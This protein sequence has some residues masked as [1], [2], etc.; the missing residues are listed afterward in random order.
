MSKFFW[1]F[2]FSA[3]WAN[4][5]AQT[6]SDS[7]YTYKRINRSLSFAQLTFGGDCL[8]LAD[9][10]RI[11]NSQTLGDFGT[12][13]MPR[14]T[15]GGLHFW[16][17]ADFYVTFPLGISFR[18]TPAFAESY[19]HQ[20]GVE[21]GLKI[22]PFALKPGRISPYVG[23]SFQPFSFGYLDKAIELPKPGTRYERFITPWQTGLTYTGK[24]YLFTAGMRYNRQNQFDYH[25]APNATER[26]HVS[27][28][29]VHL[30]ILRYLDSDKSVGTPH[31]VGQENAKYHLL[32]K[33]GKLSTWYWGAGPSAALQQSKSSFFEAEYPFFANQQLN[34]FILPDLTYG[35]YWAKGDLNVGLTGRAMLFG[36]RAFGERFAAGRI[37]FGFETYKFL[38]NYHGFVPFIG[39]TLSMEHLWL[40]HNGSPLAKTTKPA[41]GLVFG[42]DIRITQTG[43]NLLR[44]NLRYTP[45]LALEVR[46]NK[47]MF[48]HLEFNFI[49]FVHFIGRE[50]VYAQYRKN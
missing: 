31:N 38:F 41:L 9:A 39:P 13:L 21:T 28:V 7:I 50:K 36:L 34:S 16:G 12:V 45:G 32:K 23:V 5:Q 19:H 29:N 18:Q 14:A 17:H 1:L 10:Q 24:R 47:V 27:P 46:G 43:T 48:D 8:L 22:Y 26:I 49:Q 35:Y 4:F 15:I 33:H 37:S 3:Y 25:Y 42:W 40:R 30:S 44:T 11:R 2:V 6:P 20:E